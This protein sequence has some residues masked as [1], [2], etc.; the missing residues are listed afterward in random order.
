MSRFL[1]VA[2]AAA[3]MLAPIGVA[4]AAQP[5]EYVYDLSQRATM[6]PHTFEITSTIAVTGLRWGRWDRGSAVGRGM[7]QVD[8]CVPNC[9]SGHVGS[10]AAELQ[11]R[12]TRTDRGTLYY[13]Q[14]RVVG[15]ARPL[16]PAERRAVGTWGATYV[17]SDF[18]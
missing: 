2:I 8:S 17:P 7:L 18:K 12:G 13:A 4:T 6:R 1:K 5:R 10:Y 3:A 15:T 9:A 11:L 14:Y 16:P